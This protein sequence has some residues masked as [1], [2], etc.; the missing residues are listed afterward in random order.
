MGIVRKNFLIVTSMMVATFLLILGLL[1]FVMPVYYN[2]A[3]QQELKQ[4]YLS[5]VKEL[6][7]QSEAEIRSKM[8]NLDQKE[9]N[10]YLL[11]E[12]AEGE[13]L[14]PD[15]PIE[16]VYIQNENYDQIGAWTEVI[17]SR[18]GQTFHSSRRVRLSITIGY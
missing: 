15:A 18:E 4:S 11:L 13:I 3:K 8:S 5:I 17:T 9:P 7:G 2:Q 14:Y 6:N 1:Y 10:L 12:D 16:T